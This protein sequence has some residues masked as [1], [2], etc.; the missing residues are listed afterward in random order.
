MPEDFSG[1]IAQFLVFGF[2]T[3]ILYISKWQQ[4]YRF[5]GGYIDSSGS[6][7]KDPMIVEI[8]KGRGRF[9]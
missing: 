6:Q 2:L 1:F 4:S 8:M 5:I 3:F 9:F 7:W